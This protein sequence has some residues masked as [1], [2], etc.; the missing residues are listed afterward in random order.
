MM[1]NMVEK[2][3]L[4]VSPKELKKGK[5]TFLTLNIL[6]INKQSQA[7]ITYKIINVEI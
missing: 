1:S 6:S 7:D 3:D 4:E 5:L 2:I